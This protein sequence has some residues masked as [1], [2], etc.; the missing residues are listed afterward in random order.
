MIL[1]FFG[2]KITVSTVENNYLYAD[3]YL[4][5]LNLYIKDGYVPLSRIIYF[6]LADESETIEDLYLLNQDS[7]N[8]SLKNIALVCNDEELKNLIVCSQTNINENINMLE[9]SE[10]YFNFPLKNQDYMVTSFFNEQR[11]I[12]EKENV[13]NGWDFAI[14]EQTPVYSV[15]NGTVTNVNFT[16]NENIPYDE[17]NN[18]IGNN[19]TIAC[20]DYGDIYYVIFRHLYPNSNKVKVG[21]RVIHWT[22]IASVGTTGYSTGNH[23]HY[24]VLDKN[25]N[26]V[27]GMSLVDLTLIYTK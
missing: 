1:N 26:L 3:S 10:Q 6:Y 20:E 8:K 22:E 25:N 24:E 9:L 19:I 11:F 13:H 21:D 2:I 7:K 16:Q 23:L 27:D 4:N 18:N 5:S 17:S 12:Y 14:K 15:C